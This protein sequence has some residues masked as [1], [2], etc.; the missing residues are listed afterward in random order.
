MPVPLA[1]QKHD[2]EEHRQQQAEE[3]GDGENFHVVGNA[4]MRNDDQHSSKNVAARSAHLGYRRA[5]LEKMSAY[6]KFTFCACECIRVTTF[7]LI[8]S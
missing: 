2:H 5:C 6:C 8:H 4:L 7:I 1:P 3:D